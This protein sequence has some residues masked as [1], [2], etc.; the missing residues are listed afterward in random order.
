LENRKSPS[1]KVNELDN[2]ASNFY[3]SLYWAEF[4]ALEDPIYQ[5]L[6]TKLKDNRGQIISELKV[7]QGKPVDIGGYYKPD[8][9]KAAV[10]MRPSPTF[11]KIL[12][13]A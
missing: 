9:Q 4:A 7:C 2:R 5:D 6:A 10:A 11:N 1:R 8:P 12:D 13:N 3:I